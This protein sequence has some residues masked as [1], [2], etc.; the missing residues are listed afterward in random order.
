MKDLFYL[1]FKIIPNSE[2][3]LNFILGSFFTKLHL[4]LVKCSEGEIGL[5]FP[6]YDTDL[7]KLGGKIR[8]FAPTEDRLKLVLVN[9]DLKPFNSYLITG[10][11]K[12]LTKSVEQYAS[13][14]RVQPKSHP[15]RIKNRFIRKGW[16]NS[17]AEWEDRVEHKS[18]KLELPYLSLQSLSTRYKF[19]LFIEKIPA[20]EYKLGVFSC[21]GLSAQ[22]TLP[23]F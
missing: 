14:R 13:F 12:R 15:E 6:E 19:N 1:E 9:L 20:T 21:Y 10:T 5:S 23:I 17:E 4:I 3:A 8:L 7:K 11:V 22:A 16:I 2:L 18:L